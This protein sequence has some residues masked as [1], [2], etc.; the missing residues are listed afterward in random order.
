M[1]KFFLVAASLALLSGTAL[2][3]GSGSAGGAGGAGGAGETTTA[4]QPSSTDAQGTQE[5]GVSAKHN[6]E[7]GSE[8]GVTHPTQNER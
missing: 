2:A 1:R 5:T 8:N 6:S 3:A 7:V 4:Q